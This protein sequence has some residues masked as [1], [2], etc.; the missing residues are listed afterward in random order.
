MSYVFGRLGGSQ[1]VQWRL[2]GGTIPPVSPKVPPRAYFDYARIGMAQLIWW[3]TRGSS[4]P[5]PPVVGQ[6]GQ[7]YFINANIGRMMR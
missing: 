7:T 4:G 6:I 5:A 1:Y 2:Q 3:N